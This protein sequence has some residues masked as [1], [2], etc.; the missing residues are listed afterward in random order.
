MNVKLCWAI[1]SHSTGLSLVELLIGLALSSAALT[2]I[3][4]TY[5]QMKVNAHRDELRTEAVQNGRWLATTLSTSVKEAAAI[6]YLQSRQDTGQE[7]LCTWLDAAQ[8]PFTVF[9][10]AKQ[11]SA[12]ND[13]LRAARSSAG[14]I[15]ALARDG[16]RFFDD[17][18][19]GVDV[20][21]LEVRASPTDYGCA[22]NETVT[23]LVR[24]RY[25]ENKRPYSEELLAGVVQWRVTYGIVSAADSTQMEFLDAPQ[26]TN[27]RDVRALRFEIAVAPACANNAE[28]NNGAAGFR[29]VQTVALRQAP[30]SPQ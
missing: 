14:S 8:L 19:G 16:D 11:S 10:L 7:D 12:T 5:V 4:S 2:A 29:W 30:W 24:R 18:P 20:Y 28:P 26:V 25:R 13:C 6:A 15:L 9:G 3:L 23:S 27:W 1:P 22:P 21:T 17:G